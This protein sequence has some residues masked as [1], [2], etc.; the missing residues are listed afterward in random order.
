VVF[1]AS[2]MGPQSG[3]A[4]HHG[5]TVRRVVALAGD[6]VA[7]HNGSLWRNGA[8]ATGPATE[9]LGNVVWPYDGAADKVVPPGHVMVLADSR[10]DP[11]S[12]VFSV[13]PKLGEPEAGPFVP[14]ASIKGQVVA[15]ELPLW[16][17]RSLN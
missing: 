10:M 8:A 4:Q 1:R 13:R 5:W 3:H 7:I 14:V 2:T 11:R 15:I 9:G 6:T 16:R 17:M 12:D